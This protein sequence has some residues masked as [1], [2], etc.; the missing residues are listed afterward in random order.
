MNIV[1]LQRRL[2]R[3]AERM[4]QGSLS[5]TTRTCGRPGCR[6]HLGERHGPHTYLT[7]KTPEGRSS[8]VYVPAAA[9][10]EA[11]QGVAAWT[12]FWRMAVQLAAHNRDAAVARWR[13]ARR[14]TRS[15]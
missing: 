6:C 15:S 13:A 9:R 12:E 11:R 7:F 10:D 5:D 3:A 14:R 4:V 1:A 8:S 2:L